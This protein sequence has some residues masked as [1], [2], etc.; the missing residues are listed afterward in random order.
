MSS[1]LT[2][3]SATTATDDR[4]EQGKEWELVSLQR[5]ALRMAKDNVQLRAEL[6]EGSQ[7]LNEY[8][9]QLALDSI[10]LDEQIFNMNDAIDQLK[11]KEKQL[12]EQL[13]FIYSDCQRL[14]TDNETIRRG[15]PQKEAD[16]AELQRVLHIQQMKNAEVEKR[17]LSMQSETVETAKSCV[18]AVARMRDAA[19]RQLQQRRDQWRAEDELNRLEGAIAMFKAE[20][21]ISKKRLV[22]KETLDGKSL[23][24]STPMNGSREA[25]GASYGHLPPLLKAPRYSLG[26]PPSSSLVSNASRPPTTA[27]EVSVSIRQ[28]GN[29]LCQRSD[30][31]EF[32]L[33]LA[34][35]QSLRGS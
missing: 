14:E 30:C 18:R 4:D 29:M 5:K 25:K 33:R 32:R 3:R 10:Q 26:K 21:D 24:S 34:E 27:T 8:H 28:G 22:I 20:L 2:N 6:K 35:L 1:D 31:I 23:V 13:D 11:S 16:I 12:Q 7:L 9:A 15:L 19:N 17:L